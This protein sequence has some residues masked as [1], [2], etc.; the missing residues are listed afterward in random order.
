MKVNQLIKLKKE[1]LFVFLKKEI[2]KFNNIIFDIKFKKEITLK[3]VEKVT[4]NLRKNIDNIT[5][6]VIINIPKSNPGEQ[7]LVSSIITSESEFEIDNSYDSS[8]FD[9]NTDDSDYTKKLKNQNK[10]NENKNNQ[11][12]QE[13]IDQQQLEIQQNYQ[14]SLNK[15]ETKDEEFKR[16]NKKNSFYLNLLCSLKKL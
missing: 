10:F 1:K 15:I 12:Q 9:Y 13:I 6:K 14:E 5:N 4:I 16:I 3:E 2:N 8:F 7:I 11:Q